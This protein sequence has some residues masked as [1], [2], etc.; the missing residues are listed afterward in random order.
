MRNKPL[1][2]DPQRWSG[3]WG[4]YFRHRTFWW[5][6]GISLLFACFFWMICTP[7][8]E[9]NDDA[10]M[11]GMVY[12]MNGEYEP[13]M[14]FINILVGTLIKLCIQ[15]LPGVPWYPLFQ[16]AILFCSLVALVYVMLKK[17]RTPMT[18]MFFLVVLFFFFGF[19]FCGLIQFSKTSGMA[20][21]A[22][23]LLLF[24]A[25]EERARWTH[26]ALA[27]CLIF[28]GSLYRFMVFEM[29]LLMFFGVGLLLL[30]RYCRAREFKAVLRLCLPC[31]LVIALCFAA[32][33]VDY[34]AYESDPQWKEYVEFNDLRSQL[35]DYGFPDYKENKELYESVGM[36]END[37][38]TFMSWDFADPDR[39]NIE[40]M[41]KL[42]DAK[43]A[44]TISP[45]MVYHY[46]VELL[47]SLTQYQYF[48]GT[49]MA[50]IFCLLSYQ[51]GDRGKAL[52]LCYEILAFLGIQFYL[53]YK[54]RYLQNRIDV[55]L[56]L[57]LF[58]VSFCLCQGEREVLPDK[59]N[60]ALF[61]VGVVLA[62]TGGT[63]IRLE[64]IARDQEVAS[65]EY[66]PY[67]LFS[68]DPER[69]YC[70]SVASFPADLGD[71]WQV[72]PLGYQKNTV[73]MGGWRCH[74]RSIEYVWDQYGVENPYRDM[75]DNPDIYLVCNTPIQ[76]Q[77]RYIQ[78][79]YAANA[80]AYNTKILE[81]G[82]YCYKF[83]T[84][85][86]EPGIETAVDGSGQL[87]YTLEETRNSNNVAFTGSLYGVG[88]NSFS[89]NIYLGIRDEQTGEERC[90]YTTQYVA[91]NTA[92]TVDVMHGRYG[93]FRCSVSTSELP[94]DYSVT[95][96]LETEDTL[97][98]VPVEAAAIQDAG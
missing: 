43:P 95:L 19:Q 58:A 94:G 22:G 39:F 97:Y 90:Y 79:H 12:G 38:L 41:Q 17:G 67:P 34:H 52:L 4:I 8:Y 6:V 13:H 72:D 86:P 53:F 32:K 70:I 44:R 24:Y 18:T 51:R 59:R 15:W 26:Y 88:I 45:G 25:V 20:V 66:D 82:H 46:V 3:V 33:V 5:S 93:S 56:F 64:S 7:T 27:C 68:S 28:A 1:V 83:A 10:T 37:V 49:A 84:G 80:R 16:V 76:I 63:H 60:V 54:G 89:S 30:I 23:F 9:T 42:V 31:A 91:E 98:S 48:L 29:L 75:V 55:C 65:V 36:S 57:A 87:T 92:E 96:Y 61:L 50:V 77:E 2:K 74:S 85:N 62:S 47:F 35:L 71:I 78:D 21:T 81:T 40:V 73:S 11:A 14:V 69:L